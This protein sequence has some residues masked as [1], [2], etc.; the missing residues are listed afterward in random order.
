MSR[1]WTNPQ[2]YAAVRD[3]H[4]KSVFPLAKLGHPLI[5][6]AAADTAAGPDAPS[7]NQIIRC[8]RNATGRSWLEI[9]KPG[10]EWRGAV[11]YDEKAQPWLV[12]ATSGGHDAFYGEIKRGVE[13]NGPDFYMPDE[14]DYGYLKL[15]QQLRADREWKAANLMQAIECIGEALDRSRPASRNSCLTP[16]IHHSRSPICAWRSTEAAPPRSTAPTP[17]TTTP[18]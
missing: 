4:I 16:P 13:T 12:F 14:R 8:V 9:K 1:G 7:T 3:E 10:T 2:H 11:A 17:T 18:S 6:Q 15:E 5:A